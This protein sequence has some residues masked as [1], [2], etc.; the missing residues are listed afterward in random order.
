MISKILYKKANLDL[1]TALMTGNEL[2]QKIKQWNCKK[3]LISIRDDNYIL[4][5]NLLQN[6]MDFNASKDWKLEK[7]S[8]VVFPASLEK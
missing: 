6:Q 2:S 8:P 1:R 7:K 3:I 5:P 4:T